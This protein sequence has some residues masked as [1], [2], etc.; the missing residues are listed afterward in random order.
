MHDPLVVAWQIRRPWPS[1]SRM[2]DVSNPT[3]VKG[4]GGGRRWA[5]R[6]RHTHWGD[7]ETGCGEQCRSSTRDPF[8]WWKPSSYSPFMTIA[9]RGFYWPSIITVWHREPGGADSGEVCKHFRKVPGTERHE[10]TR[11]WKWH[12]HHYSIQIQPLQEL[13]R[14]VFGRCGW[15]GARS[16]KRRP[17]NVSHQWDGPRRRL[18]RIDRSLFHSD[19]STVEHAHRCCTC[20]EPAPGRPG[21]PGESPFRCERCTLHYDERRIGLRRQATLLLKTIPRGEWHP[22]TYREAAVLFKEARAAAE[23]AEEKAKAPF[24]TG[25]AGT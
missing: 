6:L 14:R 5:W 10:V 3:G 9:G 1:R 15:C 18:F 13:H 8:P 2:H 11:A 4:P 17:V 19:C 12:V 25:Y 20:Y 22:D 16:T 24:K 7:G 21:V 23:R